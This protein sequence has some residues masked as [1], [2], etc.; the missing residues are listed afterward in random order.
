MPAHIVHHR[1]DHVCAARL[2]SKMSS[3]ALPP[4][5]PRQ[6]YL[7]CTLFDAVL[8]NVYM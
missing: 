3:P 7:V 4:R 6:L 8:A 5:V 1:A 2:I